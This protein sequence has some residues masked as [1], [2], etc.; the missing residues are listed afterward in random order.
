MKVSF[1]TK[2]LKK[3]CDDEGKM[4]AVYGQNSAKKLG[5]RLNELEVA[6]SLADVFKVPSARCHELSGNLK[7][8]LSVDLAHPFRLLFKPDHEPVPTKP[9]GGL[10]RTQVTAVIII[11]VE[12]TH[13]A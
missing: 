11:E 5:N 7:G 13:R 2:K 1:K 3:I 8:V 9:D 4:V 6:N 10:D 12:D